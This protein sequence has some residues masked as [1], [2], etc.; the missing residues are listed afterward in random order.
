MVSRD[1][2]PYAVA[3]GNPAREVK[4]RFDDATVEELLAIRWWDWD[5][6]KITRN[7]QVIADGRPEQLRDCL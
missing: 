2:R 7:V 6:A 1:V 5:A 4:R 3:V